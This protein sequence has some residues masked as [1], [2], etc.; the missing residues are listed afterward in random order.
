MRRNCYYTSSS[1]DVNPLDA[2]DPMD[3]HLSILLLLEV[4][5]PSSSGDSGT[6]TSAPVPFFAQQH[7]E[8]SFLGGKQ[9]VPMWRF[10]EIG[11]PLHHP[12]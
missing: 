7:H 3:E 2:I 9:H 5:P 1:I 4:H 10:P 8:M 6:G 11:V 12:F